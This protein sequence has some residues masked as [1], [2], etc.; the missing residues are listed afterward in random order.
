MASTM[1]QNGGHDKNCWK[2]KKEIKRSSAKRK[3]SKCF[4]SFHNG[5]LKKNVDTVSNNELICEVCKWQTEE[6][7]NEYVQIDKIYC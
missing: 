2:C 5:C 3:C 1:F 6:P 7:P 4:R